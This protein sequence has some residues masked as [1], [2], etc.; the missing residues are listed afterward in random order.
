MSTTQEN[1]RE[2]T[3]NKKTHVIHLSCPITQT[4]V[5]GLQNVVLGALHQGAEAVHLRISSEGGHLASGFAAFGLLS[6]LPIPLHTHNNGN[7]ESAAV[8]L[9]LAGSDRTAA[10]HSRF[11]LHPLNWGTP[12]GQVDHSRLSEWN[13][14]LNFD[15]D[16]YCAIFKQA[17]QGAQ[18]PIDVSKHLQNEALIIGSAAATDARIV[19]RAIDSVEHKLP[20]ENIVHW[21]VTAF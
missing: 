6:S 10:E 19:T 13:G 8:L 4:S 5:Q 12:A 7:V 3:Q 2:T 15:R 9:Y 20:S 11:V 16:R 18:V 21:W 17:T 14:S 1:P